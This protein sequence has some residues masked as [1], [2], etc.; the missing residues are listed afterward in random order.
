[1]DTIPLEHD[2]CGSREALY[3]K[4]GA[5]ERIWTATP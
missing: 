2:V 1:M 3:V 5:V 4:G